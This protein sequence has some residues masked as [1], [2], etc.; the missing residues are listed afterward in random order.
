MCFL[1]RFSNHCD[2]KNRASVVFQNLANNGLLNDCL[3][4]DSREATRDELLLV[5]SPD[6]LD[7]MAS[8]T[9]MSK[10][11]L[12]KLAKEFNSVF[13]CS[14]TQKAALLSAGSALQIVDS[15][16]SGENRSGVGVCYI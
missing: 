1:F 11:A 16:I 10:S 9:K 8:T 14:E 7:K 12:D 4:I 2:P 15:I 5:H 6:Y 3:Q 13:L